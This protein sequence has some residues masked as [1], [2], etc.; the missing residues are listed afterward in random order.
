MLDFL[1]EN[2]RPTCNGGGVGISPYMFIDKNQNGM[3]EGARPNL[4][5]I[6]SE[7]EEIDDLS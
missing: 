6:M 5:S 3:R 2:K 7:R 1:C 4:Q